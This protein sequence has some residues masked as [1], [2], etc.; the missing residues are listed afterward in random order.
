MGGVIAFRRLLPALELR[1]RTIE[2]DTVSPP[3]LVDGTMVDADSSQQ[4]LASIGTPQIEIVG[5]SEP[6][7]T[8]WITEAE[9]E[10]RSAG[11][12]QS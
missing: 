10:L 8:N 11:R 5:P 6:S 2:R 7:V 1:L 9:Q 4:Q 3:Y 12:M